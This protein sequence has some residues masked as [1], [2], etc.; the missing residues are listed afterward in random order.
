MQENENDKM[1]VEENQA[2]QNQSPNS[3]EGI[4]NVCAQH[5]IRK[6]EVR[7]RKVSVLLDAVSDEI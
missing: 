6:L 2:A 3:A 4:D 1:D 5:R 7:A